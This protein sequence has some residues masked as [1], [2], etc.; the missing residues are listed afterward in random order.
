M[1]TINIII[2]MMVLSIKLN[3]QDYPP[4]GGYRTNNSMTA[5]HGT[6][7]WVSGTDT[8]KIYLTTKKVFFNI[9]GGFYWDMLTGWHLY[10]KGNIIIESSYDS[11]NVIS[12]RTF[13][14][15]NEGDPVRTLTDGT[16][17]DLSK[18]KSGALTLTLNAAGNQLSWQLKETPG[19]KVRGPNDPPYQPG[20]TLPTSMVLI[21]Q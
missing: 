21:K 6:W 1:R 17:K 5:F 19:L 11:I 4:P 12:A 13:T 16:L 8:V 2:L 18:Q 3:A 9:S 10:K 20:F 15:S 7:Q 14:G